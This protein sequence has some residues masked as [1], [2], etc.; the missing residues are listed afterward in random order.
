MKHAALANTR[1]ILCLLGAL[2]I[3]TASDSIIKWLSPSLPLHEITLVRSLVALAVVLVIVQ[4]EGGV[5]TLRTRRPGMHLARG[6]LLTLANIF[7]FVGLSAMALAETVALF[8]T[9]PLFICLL[10]QP[11]L[12]ERVGL[13]RW[14]AIGLG[15]IGVIIMV[16]PG[17]DV[18]RLVSLLPIL[19]ALCY[20]AMT[21]MTRKLGLRE[22]AG[23]MTFY[24]QVAFIAVSIA[25]GGVIGSGEFD[26]F[27]D[28]A[29]AF[30]L[31]AW[32]W[33]TPQEWGLLVAC[34]VLVCFGGYLLSQAYRLGEA[35]VVAPFEYASMPFALAAGF[36]LWGDWPDWIALAGSGLIIG[37]GLLVV[38]LENRSRRR[39]AR[40]AQIDY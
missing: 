11:V 15:G 9:A 18:F 20:A 19:A 5:G 22:T 4:F 34:G 32:R 38:M 27:D 17:S 6:L 21:M 16:R 10:S 25:I 31:R 2:V 3:L 37:G 28:P 13:P 29:L 14:F 7:F 23:A 36:I 33:P 26:R 8:F 12:G 24:I 35:P 39:V 1:G 40:Q 30:L